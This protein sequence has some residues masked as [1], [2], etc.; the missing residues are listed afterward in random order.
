MLAYGIIQKSTS[1]YA[2]RIILVKKKNDSKRICVDYRQLSSLTIKNKYPN[3]LIDE[4]L[5]EFK[6]A[7]WFIKLD[8]RVGYYQIRVAPE[9]ILKTDFRTHTDLIEF[10][11]MPFG[12]TNAPFIFQ[13]LMNVIFEDHLRKSVLVV[14]LMIFWFTIAALRVICHT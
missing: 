6:E 10:K 9:D 3:P 13:T 2:S 5:N 8:L 12:L 1:P 14:F 7:R 4:L 11:M